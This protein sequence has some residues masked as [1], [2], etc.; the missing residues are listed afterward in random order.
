MPAAGRP[1]PADD[2]GLRRAG[3]EA[4]WWLVTAL[5]ALAAFAHVQDR[6][7]AAGARRFVAEARRALDGDGLRMRADEAMRPANARSVRLGIVAAAA[8]FGAS[9]VARLVALRRT[10]RPS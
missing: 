6:V 2:A 5:L 1:T 10:R 7:T 8:V 3:S 4:R 9:G